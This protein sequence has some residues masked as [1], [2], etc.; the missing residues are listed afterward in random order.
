M[1][2]KKNE[3]PASEPEFNILDRH[4]AIKMQDGA[5][6]MEKEIG[7]PISEEERKAFGDRLAVLEIEEANLRRQKKDMQ[8]NYR[9]QINERREE[10]NK[11]AK[12]MDSG[13]DMRLGE[14][15]VDTDHQVKEVR[16]YDP[17]THECL[18]R[19]SM[20]KDEVENPGLM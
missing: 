6:R 16:T 17:N 3:I 18:E 2:K 5:V 14:V 4:Q 20:T 19:R 9:G 8:D 13:V 7:F 11:I 10:I 12:T 1:A 15:F